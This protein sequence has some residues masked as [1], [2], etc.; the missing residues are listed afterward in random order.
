MN[1]IAS[2]LRPLSG[3]RGADI[4]V[5]L[6]F[7][8]PVLRRCGLELVATDR[9]LGPARF[10]GE[11]GIPLLPWTIGRE[12]SPI[13]AGTCDFVVCSE[14]LEHLKLPTVWVMEALAGLLRPGGTLVLTTPNIA[15]LAHI[16]LLL[17]GEN[18]LEAFPEDLESG[19]DPTD[20][21]EHVRE[22][23]IREVVEAVEAAG[24]I[25]ELVQMTGWGSGGERPLPNPHLNEIMVIAA[26]TC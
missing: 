26:N 20:H 2:L 8:P 3:A 22:Y 9:D 7:L 1:V 24:L 25:V 19:A 14:V 12:P 10:A 17:A 21:I 5:G 23:S 13:A 4:G 11:Q 6:G 15:R 18:F 16:E